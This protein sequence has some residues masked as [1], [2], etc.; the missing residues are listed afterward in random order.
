MVSDQAIEHAPGLLRVDQIAID[1]ARML[2]GFLHRPLRDLVEGDA[3]DDD[4]ILALL[5]L[6]LL[7]IEIVAAEFFRE[8]R[9][10]SLAFAVRI[11]RQIDGRGALGELLQPRQYL[12]F[13]GDDGVLGLEVVLDIDTQ[14]FLGQVFHVPKRGFHVEAFA[15]IFIDR[16][17]LRGRFDDYECFCQN[18]S[19]QS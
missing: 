18:V 13:A 5:L 1:S 17:R 8:M 16:L 10:N 6:A 4:L 3:M 7:A 11:R 14:H 9:G 12:L 15:E 2:K 19:L